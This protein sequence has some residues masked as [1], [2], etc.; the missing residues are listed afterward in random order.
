M[1]SLAA[2]LGIIIGKL[3]DPV[4][5]IVVLVVTLC[6]KQKYIM[7][8]AA[9]VGAIITESVL[10]SIQVTRSWG[11][12]IVQGFIAS[13]LHAAFL[14]WVVG[15]FRKDNPVQPETGYDDKA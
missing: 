15:K 1:N 9:L 14:F 2:L 11:Q 12:G 7:I 8:V 4:S 10:T 13:L 5:F 3:L 6:S